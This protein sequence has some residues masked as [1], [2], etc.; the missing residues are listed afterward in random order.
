MATR[1]AIVWKK[2]KNTMKSLRTMTKQNYALNRVVRHPPKN[3]FGCSA[4][5]YKSMFINTQP[6]K[7][8]VANS[9]LIM[10]IWMKNDALMWQLDGQ[11]DRKMARSRVSKVKGITFLLDMATRVTIVLKEAKNTMK[12]LKTVHNEKTELCPK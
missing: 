6:S 11:T 12:S 7:Q 10:F 8:K 4:G 2:A 5:M 3:Q 1:V 9:T